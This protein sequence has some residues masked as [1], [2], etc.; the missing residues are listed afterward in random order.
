LDL[1][2]PVHQLSYYFNDYLNIGFNDWKNKFRID[3]IIL[4]IKNGELENLTLE[5][6][7]SSS[8]FA[9]RANFNKVFLSIMN[10]TPTEYVKS[11][12]LK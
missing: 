2:I 7:A 3:F 1:G 5:G 8:G 9:S 4:Q 12:N 10:Q 6:L 11:L